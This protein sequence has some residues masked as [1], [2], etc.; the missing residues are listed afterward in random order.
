MSGLASV[1]SIRIVTAERLTIV[2]TTTTGQFVTDIVVTSCRVSKEFNF[3]KILKYS[4]PDY[5]G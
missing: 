1:L 4:P 2:T 5:P 3:K